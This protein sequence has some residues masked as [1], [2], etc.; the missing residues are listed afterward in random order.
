[1]LSHWNFLETDIILKHFSEVNSNT[2]TNS[3]VDWVL[4]IKLLKGVITWIQ[5]WK[6]TDDS[7]MINFIISEVER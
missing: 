2:L 7:I 3:L 5:Y 4:N 6:N 1:M